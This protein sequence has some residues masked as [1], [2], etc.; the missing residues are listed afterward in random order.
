MRMNFAIGM[1][2]NERMDEIAEGFFGYRR[3]RPVV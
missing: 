1:G 2:G 3:R